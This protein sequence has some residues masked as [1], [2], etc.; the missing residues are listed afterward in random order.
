MGGDA[1]RRRHIQ[2][3]IPVI[4]VERR[5]RGEK[6][7]LAELRLLAEAAG[8]EVVGVVTQVRGPDPRYNIG[9]GKV[10][11]LAQLV[12]ETGARKVIFF[13]ELKPHQAYSLAK[14]LGVEVID[15]FDLILEIFAKRAGSC[16]LYTSDAADE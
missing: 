8:Y 5:V 11:E 10:E 9:S 6:S 7:L 15:R 2:G 4:L 13:N 1:G 12:K 3:P 14:E 16:L